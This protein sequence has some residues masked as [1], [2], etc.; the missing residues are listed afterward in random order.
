MSL[1]EPLR[2][3]ASSLHRLLRAREK[4]DVALHALLS[5]AGAGARAPDCAAAV[6]RVFSGPSGGKALAEA[7]KGALGGGNEGLWAA[8]LALALRGGAYAAA[9]DA[10]SAAAA[11]VEALEAAAEAATEHPGAPWAARLLVRLA[12]D[13]LAAAPKHDTATSV[14]AQNALGSA[15]RSAFKVRE[16][17]AA[18]SHSLR[19][20]SWGRY[21]LHY[22]CSPSVAGGRRT[23]LR[24]EPQRR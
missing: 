22:R 19:A 20:E 16:G 9:G 12:R 24:E 17:P 23:A 2:A 15:L 5:P 3:A 6:E 18:P 14:A 7:L 1:P 21:T 8:T 4:D 11:C 10:V 13:A